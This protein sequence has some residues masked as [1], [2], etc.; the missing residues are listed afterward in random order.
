MRSSIQRPGYVTSVDL[1]GT[2]LKSPATSIGI[3]ALAAIFSKPFKRVWTFTNL[4]DKVIVGTGKSEL[5]SNDETYPGQYLPELDI[6]QFRVCMDMRIRLTNR[7]SERFRMICLQSIFLFTNPEKCANVRK[8]THPTH[9]PKL[10]THNSCLFPAADDG[11]STPWIASR[12][13]S[14]TMR[15]T[16]SYTTQQ[17][18]STLDNR[19]DIL[20]TISAGTA[21]NLNQ[22]GKCC[23]L[24]CSWYQRLRERLCG[25]VELHLNSQVTFRITKPTSYV[26]SRRRQAGIATS[27]FFTREKRSRRKNVAQPSMA[28]T[29]PV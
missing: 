4:K 12:A 23:F 10:T 13:S 27:Y 3:S 11:A 25:L 22:P 5:F 26:H 16:L 28:Y 24:R 17:V 14:T 20:N 7:K 6:L 29:L 9:P 21:S 2:E 1:P 18:T 19:L 8:L 15:A